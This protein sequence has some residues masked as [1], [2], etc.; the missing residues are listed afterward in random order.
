[1]RNTILTKKSFQSSRVQQ[2]GRTNYIQ[3]TK[4]FWKCK[5]AQ[6]QNMDFENL[7]AK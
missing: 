3:S 7:V 1:M 4:P 5:R 2:K 6:R